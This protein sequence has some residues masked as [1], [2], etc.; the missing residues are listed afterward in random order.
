MRATQI[1]ISNEETKGKASFL[2]FCFLNT[3]SLAMTTILV[4]KIF[5]FYY[6][7][8][9]FKNMICCAN[10][11]HVCSLPS[12]KLLPKCSKNPVW[13]VLRYGIQANR[14]LNTLKKFQV[15]LLHSNSCSFYL[16]IYLPLACL[17]KSGFEIIKSCILELPALVTNMPHCIFIDSHI[18]F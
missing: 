6:D 5:N 3:M 16:D 11:V 15:A 1:N 18:F 12:Y 2:L 13:L 9:K 8:Q 4:E 7:I 10:I 14:F 17:K